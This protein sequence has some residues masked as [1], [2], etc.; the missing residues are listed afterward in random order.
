MIAHST[1]DLPDE[2]GWVCITSIWDNIYHPPT[3]LGVHMY[4]LLLYTVASGVSG[5]A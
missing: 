5:H 1:F 4:T 3:T 2:F